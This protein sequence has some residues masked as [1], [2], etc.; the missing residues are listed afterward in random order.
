[1]E[2]GGFPEPFEKR[3]ARFTRRWN[4]RRWDELL[5]RDLPKMAPARDPAIAQ[6]LASL[7]ASRSAN[8]LIYSELSRELGL[9]VDTVR[10]WMDWLE[11]L[12]LGFRV[13]PWFARIPKAVRKE[14]KWFL[15]DWSGVS[16]PLARARTF[17]ACHLLKAAEGWTDCGSGQ[18]ELRYVRDKARREADFL[19]LRDRRPW[20]LVTV[21]NSDITDRAVKDRISHPTAP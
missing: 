10:R 13:R 6:M 14:P 2:H 18:F 5:Q 16:E 12:Q 9:A 4:E 15:R 1:L 20:F 21:S 7:L 8:Y 11:R 3:D 17:V 19:M